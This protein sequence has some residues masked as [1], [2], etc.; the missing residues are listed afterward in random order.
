[1]LWALWGKNDFGICQWDLLKILM[2][3]EF[4]KY[5]AYQPWNPNSKFILI[6]I[7]I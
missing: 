5:S 1:M 3:G 2:H 7:L 6:Y 4:P